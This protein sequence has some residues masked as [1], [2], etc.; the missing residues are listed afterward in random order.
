LPFFT[1]FSRALQ[2]SFIFM[3]HD[4]RRLAMTP[5]FY[6][7]KGR[8]RGAVMN[9]KIRYFL[10][11]S[12]SVFSLL[13]SFPAS[14]EQAD[15]RTLSPYFV[16]AGEG[17][18]IEQFPLK[19]TN[20]SVNIEGVIADVHVIQ[21]YANEGD[22]PI[23]AT[24][25]FPASTQASVHGMTM[26][27]GERVV[28]AAIKERETAKAEFVAAKEQGKSASLLE[29]QRPNVFAMNVANIMP[30]DDVQ[31]DLH[32][33]ELLIPT[34]GTYEF[35]YPT[36]VGPRYSNQPEVGAAETDKWVKSPYLPEGNV[37]PTSF[38]IAA[39]ISTGIPL[40]DLSCPSH[41]VD[42][43]W[44]TSSNARMTL[45]PSGEFAGDRDFILR[46]RLTGKVIQSGLMLYQGDKE[47]LF[48]LMVQPPERIKPADIPPREYIFVLDVS[49]SMFGFP[50]DTAKAL[51]RDL[52]GHLRPI[53]KFNVVL[54]SGASVTMAPSSIPATAGN[55]DNAITL[56][57][58]QRGGGGTELAAAL[59]K[60]F[61]LPA[62]EA[63]SRTVVVITDGF[64]AA[65]KETFE[66]IQ[67]NL[68]RSNVFS[69][70]IGHGVNRYLVEGVA[71]A[72]TGESF[73]VTKPQDAPEAAARF[74][75]YVESPLLTD[76][77]VRFKD[78]DAYDVEPPKIPDLF[79][80]R[81][82]VVFGKWRGEP[83]GEIE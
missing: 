77:E 73:V 17:S 18:P 13:L 68:G 71:K 34:A 9:N 81:P 39:S 63:F 28:T 54:F 26:V 52:I 43:Q 3:R 78:F 22:Q 83:K 1:R 50:L 70:G 24:Y 20:V 2:I 19:E 62:E 48:L 10:Y 42:V 16:V 6:H 65:E 51:I 25:V 47:N 67:D 60:A 29:Q 58:A 27:I 80:K 15:D 38:N 30:K 49:G 66:L 32:Y 56:I 41:K 31:I 69:F 53:D 45:T 4:L 59:R 46:Y 36:V 74:R 33:S 57:N 7:T 44:T 61:A 55:I 82:L 76:I 37:P 35:V 21:K 12:A 23:N 11:L 40:Q 72:G 14:G 79:A 5:I 64:I 8:K 75:A